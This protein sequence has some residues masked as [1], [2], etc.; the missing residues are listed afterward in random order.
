MSNDGRSQLGLTSRW[1]PA[2]LPAVIVGPGL[3]PAGARSAGTVLGTALNGG[4]L[5][6]TG[7]TSLPRAPAVDG[8]AAV[9]DLGLLQHW[10]SRAGSSARMQVWFDTEDPAVLAEVRTALQRAGIEIAGVRRVSDV[11]DTYDSSVPAWSLQL[12]VLAAAAG[13]VLAALVLVLL[14]ASTWRRR[15][16][17]L[18]CLGLTGVPR[19]GL[20]R[21]AVGEQLP[22]VL[23]AVLVGAGCGLL[24]AVLALPAVPLFAQPRDA[25][26]LELSA[27]WGSVLT[28]LVVALLVLGLVAW[29]CGRTVAARAR[30]S[31]VREV[32]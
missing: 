6:L 16:R 14:V 5:N 12:G 1:F 4:Q 2:A 27:P 11:R 13:L 24:G 15:S 32:L 9:V 18:A 25:S 26:T 21:V 20:G 3:T 8:P 17:D 31:R 29:L 10:G 30:L 22:V 19:R 28:V 23:L 7:I